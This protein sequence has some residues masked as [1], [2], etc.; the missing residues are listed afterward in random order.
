[1]LTPHFGEEEML[2]RHCGRGVFHPGFLD[3]L[4]ELREGFGRQMRVLS[5]AR[6]AA[7][8]ASVGGHPKSLHVFDVEQHPGMR[9]AMAVD[10]AIPDGAYRGD[11]FAKAWVRLWSVGWNAKRGFLHLD[12]RVDLD[13]PQTTFDY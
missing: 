7:H 11:L 5:G 10:V 8:N 6:C 3:R 2:C 4:E 1:M 13:L 12:R 9:G